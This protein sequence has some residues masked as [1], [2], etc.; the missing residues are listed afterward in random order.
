MT[1]SKFVELVEQVRE[2]QKKYFKEKDPVTKQ[3]Y[4][5]KSKDLERDLDDACIRYHGAGFEEEA[6]F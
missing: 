6:S 5:K 4:L 2:T 3:M 1:E